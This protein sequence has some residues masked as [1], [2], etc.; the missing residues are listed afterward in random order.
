MGGTKTH[1]SAGEPLTSSYSWIG[2]GALGTIGEVGVTTSIDARVPLSDNPTPDQFSS[3]HPAIVHF[4]L[5]DGSVRPISTKT[6]C[7]TMH[8]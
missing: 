7:L 3:Y 8:T 2:C 6:D 1:P 5:V 4:C